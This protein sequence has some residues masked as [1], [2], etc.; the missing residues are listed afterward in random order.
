MDLKPLILLI[1]LLTACSNDTPDETTN[2]INQSTRLSDTLVS[3]TDVGDF[4][5]RLISEKISYSPDE[6]VMM[7]GK[8]KY[9]G[10]EEEMEIGYL[11]SP[12]F[13]DIVEI[14]RGLEI[15]YMMDGTEQTTILQKNKW[16]EESFEKKIGFRDS[17]EHAEFYHLFMDEK[18]FPIGE[19]EIELRTNFET[20]IEE[21]PERHNYISSIV[22]E[23]KE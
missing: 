19:Y 3:E 18:G 11:E 12:F 7:K 1:I 9:I 16:Y 13:F 10:D 22:I 5:L 6:E 23:V 21:E 14:N 2:E 8:L 20:F 15:P 17:D 4:V